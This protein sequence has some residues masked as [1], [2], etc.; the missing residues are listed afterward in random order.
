MGL[1]MYLTAERYLWRDDETRGKIS[2][3]FPELEIVGGEV[4][5][6]TAS[7]ITWRKA[8]AIHNWFVQN[9]QDGVDECQRSYVSTEKLQALHDIAVEVLNDH[10]KAAEL[11]PSKGGFFF[12]SV[13]Y[14]EWY[15]S[16]LKE[17]RKSLSKILANLESLK[18]YDFY[19]NS[20]W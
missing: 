10:D 11:L 2:A 5:S 1:D 20:S 4:E 12:G 18:K 6:I 9:V 17:T 13:E 14:D 15:F 3:F 19:Y 16:D 7:L 8:N